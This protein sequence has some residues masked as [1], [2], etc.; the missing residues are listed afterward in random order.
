VTQLADSLDATGTVRHNFRINLLE[1]A[2]FISSLAFVSPQIVLPALVVELGGNNVIVGLLSALVYAAA[3]LP[4]IIAARFTETHPWKKPWAL[5]L[6]LMQRLAVL[7]LAVV[8][9]LLGARGGAAPIVA[10]L[11]VYTMG[12][13]LAGLAAP[14]W[15]DFYAKLSPIHLRGRLSGLRNALG[16]AGAFLFGFVLTLL[17]SVFSF[18][19]NYALALMMGFVLQLASML[20]Q[21]LL[22]ER[23]P[24]RTAE[25]KP[26]F[27]FFRDLPGVLRGDRE[28]RQFM[29]AA[30]VMTPGT[31][32]VGFFVAYALRELHVDASF[33]GIFTV[34]MV[35]GQVVSALANGFLSD[36]FG[37][38][39]VL[40]GSGIATSCAS[41]GALLAPTGAWFI[42]I[43][44]FVGITVGYELMARMNIAAEYSPVEK[45]STYVG[46]MN[47]M[48]APFYVSGLLGGVIAETLG[49]S[50]LFGLGLIFSVAGTLLLI[51]RVRD[52]R[53]LPSRATAE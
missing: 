29:V 17:L 14:G 38:K 50:A 16:S 53:F 37:N 1:G 21:F 51:F 23:A 39:V 19:A 8:V 35:L 26:F 20:L 34:A 10:F 25:R 43:F 28:F 12:Q 52:P 33:V 4:Q 9:W 2:L 46:L 42:G 36:R 31:M 49:F 13:V 18:P 40:V 24:S 27:A 6:G 15:F 47:A 5:T 44:A 11:V 41:L 7:M 48:L 30:M 45:R 3:F 22:I 32:P